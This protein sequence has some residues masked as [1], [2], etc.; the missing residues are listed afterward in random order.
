VFLISNFKLSAPGLIKSLRCNDLAAIIAAKL[1]LFKPI[2]LLKF[3]FAAM[4]AA[5]N[6]IAKPCL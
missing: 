2:G 4:I 5:N 3:V 6:V 1:A